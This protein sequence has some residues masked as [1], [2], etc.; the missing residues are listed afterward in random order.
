MSLKCAKCRKVF[1]GVIEIRNA[2]PRIPDLMDRIV[3]GEEV[4]SGEC[5]ICG[6]LVYVHSDGADVVCNVCGDEVELQDIR[7]HL[8]IH[9]PNAEQMSWEA[10]RAVFTGRWD[11]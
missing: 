6:A 2:F 1:A 8:Q 11:N 4:P 5:P 9:N 10:L 7:T 3:P